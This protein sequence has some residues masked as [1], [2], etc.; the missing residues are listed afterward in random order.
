MER[1]SAL[2]STCLMLIR[3][4]INL[5]WYNWWLRRNLSKYSACSFTPLRAFGHTDMNITSSLIQ[6][7]LSV[8][9]TSRCMDEWM[10]ERMV[11]TEYV[12]MNVSV[13]VFRC[14]LFSYENET[15]SS[16]I[17]LI[18][19]F[20]DFGWPLRRCVIRLHRFKPKHLCDRHEDQSTGRVVKLWRSLR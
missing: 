3:S 4:V 16:V 8:A 19:W 15:M 10:N 17:E 14:D 1:E 11:D 12:W 2:C 18:D 20:V 7:V 9:F 5:L 6:N 13:G